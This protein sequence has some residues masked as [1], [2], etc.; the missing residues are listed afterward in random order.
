MSSGLFQ[1]VVCMLVSFM[2][3][4]EGLEL[5]LARVHIAAPRFMESRED[6]GEAATPTGLGQ[7][8]HA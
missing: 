8:S 2:T 6:T 1:T 5:I 4:A 3:R 7:S